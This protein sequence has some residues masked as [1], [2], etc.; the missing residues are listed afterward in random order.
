MQAKCSFKRPIGNAHRTCLFTAV[1]I[2]NWNHDSHFSL[3]WLDQLGRF[4]PTG[5]L[6]G[7]FMPAKKHQT[8][9]RGGRPGFVLVITFCIICQAFRPNIPQVRNRSLLSLSPYQLIYLTLVSHTDLN[10]TP[11]GTQGHFVVQSRITKTVKI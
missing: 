2:D 1:S 5:P 3:D 8:H 7:G 6:F 10:Q 4:A 9:S 11:N